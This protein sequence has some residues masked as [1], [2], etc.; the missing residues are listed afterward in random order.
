MNRFFV[1]CAHMINNCGFREDVIPLLRWFA[2][3]SFSQVKKLYLAVQR[4]YNSISVK[5]WWTEGF[6]S[7]H[8][9]FAKTLNLISESPDF[10][11]S[12]RFRLK[13]TSMEQHK[14]HQKKLCGVCGW[15][16]G[17]LR[18]KELL[19]QCTY[20]IY[21]HLDLQSWLP[22]WF[23][24]VLHQPKTVKRRVPYLAKVRRHVRK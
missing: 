8:C 23:H 11:T 24:E 12:Y 7:V 5:V 20:P 22:H 15:C 14:E 9:I 17:S 2:T 4:L 18:G 10:Y 21:S 1:A 13:I 3:C 19:Y 6:F 16:F